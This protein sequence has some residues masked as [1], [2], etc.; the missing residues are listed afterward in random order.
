MPPFKRTDRLNEQFKQEIALLL[1]DELRDPRVGLVTVT[2]VQTSRELDHAKV[3][4]TML[5]DEVQ[6][7]QAL[8]GLHSAA[9][10]LRTQLSKRLHM[11]RVP[12]LHFQ[13]DRV[14]EEATRIE[15][16]LRAVLPADA[17]PPDPDA[18]RDG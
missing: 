1:R 13:L 15:G 2:A 17:P 8:S 14:L 6:K 5:G 16:L 9:P 18:E 10:F 3:Y 7:A 11:R 4:V 12:E